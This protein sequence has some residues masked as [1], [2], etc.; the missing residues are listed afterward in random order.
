MIPSHNNS[1][2]ARREMRANAK[3]DAQAVKESP[4]AKMY[5]CANALVELGCVTKTATG[6]KVTMPQMSRNSPL[7]VFNVI[8]GKC[9]CLNDCEHLLAAELYAAKI[10]TNDADFLDMCEASGAKVLRVEL[11]EEENVRLDRKFDEEILGVRYAQQEII[12][13]YEN[14]NYEPQNNGGV[15]AELCGCKV[16]WNDKFYE[17][18]CAAHACEHEE[19]EYYVSE[20]KE[21]W[22]LAV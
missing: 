14:D 1:V 16:N 11:T 2:N 4:V 22:R 5:R 3:T 18:R 7:R 20:L 21:T 10:E 8:A 6:Y 12:D 19:I 13:H 15:V 9:D 17:S